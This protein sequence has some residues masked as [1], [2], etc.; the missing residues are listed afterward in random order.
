[1]AMGRAAGKPR[2]D[3]VSSQSGRE[4]VGSN[5]SSWGS[6][7]RNLSTL[8]QLRPSAVA[9]A[10]VASGSASSSCHDPLW[11]LL[12]VRPTRGCISGVAAQLHASAFGHSFPLH[13]GGLGQHFAVCASPVCMLLAAARSCPSI[14]C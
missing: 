8:V 11:V 12:C 2:E 10:A 7:S 13:L 3:A 4:Q 14:L 6:S 1:M 9:A 5:S